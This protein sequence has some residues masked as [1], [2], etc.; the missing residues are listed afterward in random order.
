MAKQNLNIHQ[1]IDF[2]PSFWKKLAVFIKKWIKQDV[3]AGEVQKAWGNGLRYSS[4][5]LK[6]KLNEM[7]RFTDNKKLGSPRTLKSGELKTYK[8]NNLQGKNTNTSSKPNMFLT[9][10][11]INGLDYTSS[12]KNSMKMSYKQKDADKILGNEKRGRSIRT[13]NDK[14]MNKTRKK[15]EDQLD[16]N[17]RN[18]ARKK[19]TI[20]V[21]A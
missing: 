15:I 8:N 11:T 12:T 16:K 3:L 17:I 7:R 10:E 5:Y 4:Q 1:V 14:N 21:G 9:G 6:Y 2:K 19:I 13:L 18:W 20:T